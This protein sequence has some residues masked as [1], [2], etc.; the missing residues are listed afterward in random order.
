MIIVLSSV[1]LT[2]CHLKHDWQEATCTEPKTCFVCN[3]TKGEP[4]GHT[5]EEATC[6]EP[7]TCSVC[8]KAKGETLEHA[9]QEAT[10]TEP[11]TCFVC[12][13]TEGEV[14]EHAWQEATCTEPRTCSVCGKAEGEALGHTWKETACTEP[15]SC[16]VCGVTEGEALGHAWQEATCTKPKTCAVCS[17]TVGEELGHAWQEATCTVPKTC[18]VCGAT[19]GELAEHAFDGNGNCSVCHLRKIE[20][21]WENVRDYLKASCS[22]SSDGADYRVIVTITPT[23]SNYS[24]QDAQI[25][26]GLNL[27][28]YNGEDI[29]LS[30]DTPLDF[31]FNDREHY[32]DLGKD[33]CLTIEGHFPKDYDLDSHSPLFLWPKGYCIAE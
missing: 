18:S 13:K 22:T 15:R 10:C 16:S 20:L 1:L 4:L 25:H 2:G 21:T 19:E 6:T 11:K 33:G 26:I 8:G 5:W 24:F 31:N 3:K 9:W 17:V 23:S 27:E 14:L 29:I 7:K 32:Y 12:G 28:R 30:L